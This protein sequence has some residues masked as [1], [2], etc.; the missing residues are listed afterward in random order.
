ML[1]KLMKYDWL[2]V[3]RVEGI[4][5]AIMGIYGLIVAVMIQTPMY[6]G[7]VTGHESSDSVEAFAFVS[8]GFG[9]FALGLLIV[10]VNLASI[11]YLAVRFYHSMYDDEGYLTHTLPATTMERLGSKIIVGYLWYMIIMLAIAASLGFIFISAVIV[12]Y[13][14]GYTFKQVLDTVYG[15]IPYL[16]E[17]LKENKGTIVHISMYGVFSAILS[18]F[19]TIAHI[20]GALTIGQLFKKNRGLMGIV[21]YFIISWGTNIIMTIITGL[22]SAFSAKRIYSL[23]K[24]LGS[25]F[26]NSGF[27]VR[28]DLKLIV[29]LAVAIALVFVSKYIIDEKLNLL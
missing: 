26:V 28:Y 2:S 6:S 15:W 5:A 21:F 10:S 20:Y 19:I 12:G 9:I 8:G 24:G 17:Y 22:I 11:I 3:C 16:P 18:P 7:F 23:N 29:T 27:F 4:L 14:A 13:R 25:E 1:T